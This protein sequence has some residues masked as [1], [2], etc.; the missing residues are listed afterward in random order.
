M[1][2]ISSQVADTKTMTMKMAIT[3]LLRTNANMENTLLSIIA[4]SRYFG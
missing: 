2:G 4:R 3:T 1:S